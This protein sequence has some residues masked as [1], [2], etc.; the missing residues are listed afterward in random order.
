MGGQKG[1]KLDIRLPKNQ[2]QALLSVSLVGCSQLVLLDVV[3]DEGKSLGLLTVV[4]DGDGGSSLDLSGGTVLV[5][6][7][8][9]EPLT[10]VVSGLDLNEG[11]AV[12][13]AKSLKTRF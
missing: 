9:S 10:E 2:D 6:L 12:R 3:K 1:N 13:L 7:A 8:V 4:L 5:V 11:D